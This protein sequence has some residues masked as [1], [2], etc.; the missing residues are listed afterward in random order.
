MIDSKTGKRI[1]VLIDDNS[2]PYIR[3]STWND[4]DALEELLSDKYD[5]LY[6]IK[7]PKISEKMAGRSIILEMLPTLRSYKGFSM[8]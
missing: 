2:G 8:K 6:E 5:V 3:V 4:A 1:F 7:P